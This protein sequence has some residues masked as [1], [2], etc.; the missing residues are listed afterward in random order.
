M[1]DKTFFNAFRAEMQA[2]MD[3]VAAKHG[4]RIKMKGITYNDTWFRFT[5]EAQ[6]LTESGL[7]ALSDADARHILLL[8]EGMGE[9]SPDQL[10]AVRLEYAGKTYAIVGL[11]TRASKKPI[12]MVEIET[13]KR[14]KCD[15][16]FV[17]ARIGNQLKTT[18][19]A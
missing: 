7:P 8:V 9:S 14:V 4:I 18:A 17:R 3:T 16:Y 10:R 1:F 2:A 11:T 12:E 5:T 19:T 6:A 13:G 15:K